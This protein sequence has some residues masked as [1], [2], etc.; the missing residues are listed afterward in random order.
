MHVLWI[1][2][3]QASW[4]TS[5]WWIWIQSSLDIGTLTRCITSLS[6]RSCPITHSSMSSAGISHNTWNMAF[7]LLA[8]LW[9]FPNYFQKEKMKN[10]AHYKFVQFVLLR[11]LHATDRLISHSYGIHSLLM[12]AKLELTPYTKKNKCKVLNF[13]WI[14]FYF[15]NWNWQLTWL[16][17]VW[18][19]GY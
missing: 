8:K 19:M 9:N 2:I 18:S 16:E 4:Q 10:F 11:S 5:F 14:F 7:V 6:M 15:S 13:S 12:W 17:F 3:V 1:I